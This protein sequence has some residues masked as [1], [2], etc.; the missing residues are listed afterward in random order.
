MK[1]TNFSVKNFKSIKSIDNIALNT[2]NSFIGTNNA[3]KSNILKGF[4]KTFDIIKKL[5]KQYTLVSSE[6]DFSKEHFFQMD[7]HKNI[8]FGVQISL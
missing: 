3:G 1:I 7:I 4:V 6:I 8:V 2:I 5:L